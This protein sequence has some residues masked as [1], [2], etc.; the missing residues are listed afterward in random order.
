M[1]FPA[2]SYALIAAC[3]TALAVGQVLFKIC[4]SRIGEILDLVRDG[5]TLGIFLL[6]LAIYAA[7]TVG[8]IIALKT[9]PLNQAYVLMSASFIAVP[10]M[11]YLVLGE[12]IAPQL[13]VGSV[14]ICVGVI[15]A[16]ADW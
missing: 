11:S 2:T 7:S 5:P 8:W 4:S 12:K 16:S 13:V 6:A 3:V 1:S 15:I 9:I 10:M 14:V